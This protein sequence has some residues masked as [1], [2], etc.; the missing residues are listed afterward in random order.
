MP[1]LLALQTRRQ[2]P[3]QALGRGP[4]PSLSPN[5]FAGWA[6]GGGMKMA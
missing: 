6:G 5:L 3:R 1:R 2:Q 4:R